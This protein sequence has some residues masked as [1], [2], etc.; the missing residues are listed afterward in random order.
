LP[1]LHKSLREGIHW[2]NLAW[3]PVAISSWTPTTYKTRNWAEYNL[4]LK[5]RGSPSIWFDPEMSWEAE[6]SGRRGRQ[7]TYSDAAI[8]ACLTLKVLFGLPLRQ[9]TGFVESLLKRVGLDWSMPEDVVRRHTLPGICTITS[10]TCGHSI[11]Y[12]TGACKACCR[13]DTF[14][15]SLDACAVHKE[16]KWCC[17]SLVRYGDG[18][19]CC[20]K[21]KEVGTRPSRDGFQAVRSN[22]GRPSS[23]IPLRIRTPILAS[24]F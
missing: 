23:V 24:V 4:V 11:Y 20:M 18:R 8:Q 1:L 2:S 12:L 3:W 5:Q 14:A 22:L 15:F 9:T 16:V 17:R 13:E 10:P 7:R 19:R 6:A 21:R